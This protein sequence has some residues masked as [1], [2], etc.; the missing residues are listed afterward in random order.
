MSSKRKRNLTSKV[1]ITSTHDSVARDAT[2]TTTAKART[3]TFNRQP[4]GRL[5]Q[6]SET[7]DVIVSAEDLAVLQRHPEFDIPTDSFLDFE[8]SVHTDLSA[9]DI[10]EPVVKKPQVCLSTLI[11]Q[12]LLTLFLGESK[13]HMA[14]IPRS[15]P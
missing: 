9:T 11:S 2:S 4:T 14:T 3:F 12:R 6:Q 5:V 8:Q 1:E 10:P 15:L 7:A 13:C